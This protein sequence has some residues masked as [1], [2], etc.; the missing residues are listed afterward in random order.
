MTLTF[1]NDN[2]VIVYALERNIAYARRTQQVFVAQCIW[3]IASIIRL[4]LSLVTHIDNLQGRM[5]DNQR[6]REGD[7][8]PLSSTGYQAVSPIPRDLTKDQRL[9][10]ILED[11]EKAIQQSLQRRWENKKGQ[12]NPLASTKSLL[13]KDRK[14]RKQFKNIRLQKEYPKTEGIE[15]SEVERRKVAGEC[16]HCA[17]PSDSKGSHRVKDCIRPI[18]LSKGTASHPKAKEYQWLKVAALAS[19]NNESI[20]GEEE[21]SHENNSEETSDKSE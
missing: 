17:W 13:K 12:I 18:K 2:E 3:W 4:Q 20:T 5:V 15:P 7:P 10:Q 14:N 11:A 21:S 6:S 1:E 16:L 8:E 19:I 9:D